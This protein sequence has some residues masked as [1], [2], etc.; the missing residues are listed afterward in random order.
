MVVSK[1]LYELK[2]Y[3]VENLVDYRAW[4]LMPE[5]VT[6]QPSATPVT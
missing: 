2:R 5:H 3:N 4:G 6:T 1:S